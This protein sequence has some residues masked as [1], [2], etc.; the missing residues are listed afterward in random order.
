MLAVIIAGSEKDNN[1]VQKIINGLSEFGI[2]HMN[3]VASAH[4]N[5]LNVLKILEN[6]VHERAVF[7]TVAGRSNAL[8][9]FCAANTTLPVLACP[10]FSDKMDMMVNIHSTLQMPSNV[11]AMT[12]L[13]PRNCALAAAKILKL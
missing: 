10:P 11:P 1:H 3:Y 13:D 5:P 6:Y 2:K 7:I 9:G 12:V 4:K 8:S